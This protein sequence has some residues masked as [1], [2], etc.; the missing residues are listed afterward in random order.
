MDSQELIAK[1]Q[2]KDEMVRA[3]AVLQ[4]GQ[5]GAAAVR[6]L[7]GIMGTAEMEIARSARNALW[8]IVR[9]AGRP[10]AQADAKAA[11]A[12]LL[13]LTQDGQPL[14]VRREAL[15]MLSEIAGDEAVDVISPLLTN[16]DLRE[17]ARMTLQRL[18]SERS[19]AALQ[20]ALKSVPDHF[21]PNIA[22]SLRQRGV[23]V[24]GLPSAKLVPTKPTAVKPVG[25]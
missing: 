8:Q 24:A 17:D 19:L 7:A 4:A 9:H 20:G 15:W 18:P 22:V 5:A 13:P 11:V 12:E 21:K 23:E 3:A 14:P 1:I 6:P 16:V 10:G 25:R 2:D